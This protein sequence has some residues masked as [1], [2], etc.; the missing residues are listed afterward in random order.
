MLQTSLKAPKPTTKSSQ[1]YKLRTSFLEPQDALK[2]PSKQSP[3]NCRSCL[4]KHK[5]RYRLELCSFP[6]MEPQT[7][8]PIPEATELCILEDAEAMQQEYGLRKNV[9]PFLCIPRS[10]PTASALKAPSA[11]AMKVPSEDSLQVSS[12]DSLEV[13]SADTL[14]LLSIDSLEVPSEDTLEVPS[15]DTLE[16]PSEDTLEVP[17]ASVVATS[18]SVASKRTSAGAPK[19]TIKIQLHKQ[20]KQD[21]EKH[22]FSL[23]LVFV[24][25][26]HP[27]PGNQ[28]FSVPEA[29]EI[30][31]PGTPFTY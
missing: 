24:N 20:K 30:T 19:P 6:S 10:A 8:V 25:T 18:P 14:E 22:C 11:D 26:N 28:H 23:N 21:K 27:T 9:C 3:E 1:A 4:F 31:D 17:C 7:R 16:V 29:T 2:N 5:K 15:A 12:A 13:L